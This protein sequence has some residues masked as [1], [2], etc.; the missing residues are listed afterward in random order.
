MLARRGDRSGTLGGGQGVGGDLHVPEVLEELLQHV[1]HEGT[2]APVR[3]GH[4]VP[5]RVVSLGGS[6]VELEGQRARPVC[7]VGEAR[8]QLGDGGGGG[9]LGVAVPVAV[10][11]GVN[12]S[13][14]V[15][16]S[17]A[18][19]TANRASLSVVTTNVS[20]WAVSFA[21]PAVMVANPGTVTAAAPPTVWFG[22]TANAGAS[23]TA[24]TVMVTVAGADS[25]LAALRIRYVNVSVPLKFAPGV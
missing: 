15:T 1:Q 13:V 2:V 20:A 7:R 25:S 3:S 24:V 21:A 5:E 9:E 19:R 11:A 22:P 17:I 16:G 14:P 18:G 8:P 6:L 12:V 10:A 4:E 23:L